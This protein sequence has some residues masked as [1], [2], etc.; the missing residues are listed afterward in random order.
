MSDY[1]IHGHCDEKFAAVREAFTKNF[2][3]GLELGAS[4]AV[5]VDGEMVVD[6]WGGFA[7]VDRTRVWEKDTTVAVSSCSKIPVTLCGLMLVDRGLLDL[8][9][10]VATYWPEFSQNGK[11]NVLVRHIFSHSSGLPGLDGLP[12]QE[13]MS[14]WDEAS[15]GSPHKNPGRSPAPKLHIIPSHTVI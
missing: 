1:P 8:D 3:D 6:L 15:N 12:G 4:Y 9:K 5:S 2:E 14:D 11:E 7:S 13:I 10:P